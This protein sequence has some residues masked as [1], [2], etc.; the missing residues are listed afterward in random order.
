[1]LQSQSLW[2]L[3]SQKQRVRWTEGCLKEMESQQKSIKCTTYQI[4][5]AESS[6]LSTVPTEWWDPAKAPRKRNAK[7]IHH[8]SVAVVEPSTNTKTPEEASSFIATSRNSCGEVLTLHH[9]M[10]LD[11]VL[12]LHHPMDLDLITGDRLETSDE[13]PD[14]LETSDECPDGQQFFGACPD[15]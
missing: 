5:P 6:N 8:A 7:S 3:P 14:R 13:C 12:T 1:M 2:H 9:P 11:E 15:G 10:D 4:C